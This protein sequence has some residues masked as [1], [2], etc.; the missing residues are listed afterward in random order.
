MEADGIITTDAASSSD[1]TVD[2]SRVRRDLCTLFLMNFVPY[3]G[4]Y[5]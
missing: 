3:S 1:T 5:V 2:F 4:V